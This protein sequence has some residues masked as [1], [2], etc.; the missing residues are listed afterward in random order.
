MSPIAVRSDLARC[1]ERFEVEQRS[2]ESLAFR[3]SFR[4]PPSLAGPP[5]R[6]HGGLHPSVRLL[7]P[8]ERLTSASFVRDSRLALDLSVRRSIALGADV[9]IE[10]TLT[11]DRDGSVRLSTRTDGTDR[12]DGELRTGVA[13]E[14]ATVLER[15][16]ERI[17]AD[18]ADGES[19]ILA[20]AENMA[21]EVGRRLVTIRVDSSFGARG[22]VPLSRFLGEGRTVDPTFAGAALDVIGAYAVGMTLR[23]RLFTTHLALVLHGSASLDDTSFVLL[24]D[25]HGVDVEGSALEKVAIDGVRVGERRVEVL[26]ADAAL[27]KAYGHGFVSLVPVRSS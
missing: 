1:L 3:G 12:L 5:S 15:F 6:L 17:A 9:R 22:A 24:G 19:Q 7:L 14:S 10:G 4:A 2:P 23:S 26:L 20:D 13:D 21:F 8:L 11:R 27:T 25:R 16:R 18:R